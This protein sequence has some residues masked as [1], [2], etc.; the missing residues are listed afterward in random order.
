MAWQRT[1]LK[2]VNKNLL[3]KFAA[4]MGETEAWFKG[5]SA[6]LAGEKKSLQAQIKM[7]GRQANKKFL[8]IF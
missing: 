7:Y 1:G 6:R 3:G 4:C 8:G 5:E 2:G